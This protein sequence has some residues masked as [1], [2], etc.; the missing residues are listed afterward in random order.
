MNTQTS[1]TFARLLAGLP[2]DPGAELILR[3]DGERATATLRHDGRQPRVFVATDNSP[4]ELLPSTD[5]GLPGHLLLAEPATLA[6]AIEPHLGPMA[7]ARIVAWRPGRRAVVQ[8]ALKSGAVAWLK[9]LDRKTWKR[10]NRVFD[11][12]AEAMPPMRLCLPQHRFPEF[13]GYLAAA[14]PGTSLRTLLAQGNA[15]PLTVLTR[16]LLALGYT[17][18][19]GDLPVIDFASVRAASLGMLTKGAVL[20]ADLDTI[21]AHLTDLPQPPSLAQ[22]SLVHGDLH[23][24]QLFVDD[25]GTSLIDLE[26]LALGDGRFD[27]ANL[28]EHIRLRDLQ[29]HG[30][31][32]GL[33][34]AVLARCGM[35]PEAPATRAFRAVVRARLCGVYALRPR[36]NEL[37]TRLRSETLTLLELCS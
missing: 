1:G 20:R 4:H 25:H 16:S 3:H 14:A 13:C 5:A 17:R 8:V 23:D 10:A 36:W 18:T 29:Q 19:H 26:G 11:A 37:V 7:S 31:D 28:A 12:V 21:A 15:P 22:P 30:C 35:H 34:D 2:T 9:L 33:A 32:Q 24:K 27:L 6:T